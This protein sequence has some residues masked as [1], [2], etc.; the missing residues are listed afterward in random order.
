MSLVV[1][2]AAPKFNLENIELGTLMWAK[3][4]YWDEGQGGFVCSMS[5]DEIIVQYQPGISNVTN[6]LEI[7]AQEVVDGEWDEIRW[8]KDL[9]KIFCYPEQDVGGVT[10]PPLIEEEEDF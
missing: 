7:K 8:S 4:K 9:D 6:H 2:N 3:N 5:E 1:E 10:P